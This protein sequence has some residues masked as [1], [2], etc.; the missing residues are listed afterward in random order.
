MSTSGVYRLQ[1]LHQMHNVHWITSTPVDVGSVVLG[2]VVVVVDVVV[3]V[4]L[5]D[6]DGD[7]VVVVVDVGV[8]VVVEV[9]VVVVVVGGL[10][11]THVTYRQLHW[12]PNL[13]PNVSVC[14]NGW[15]Q[16]TWTTIACRDEPMADNI[17]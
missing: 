8:D 1:S 17:C 11:A 4:V 15:R 10:G 13:H 7:V 6:V 14:L 3:V 16:H 9:T 12:R 5:D 2:V